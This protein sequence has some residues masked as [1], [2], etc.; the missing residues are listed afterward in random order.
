MVNEPSLTVDSPPKT[1]AKAAVPDVPAYAAGLDSRD[2]LFL[3]A[4]RIFRSELD[5]LSA[6]L[7]PQRELPL[8]QEIH[9]SRIAL[10]RLRVALSVFRDFMPAQV[11][12]FRV[13]FRWL[14]QA[15]GE[16]RDLDVYEETLQG[17]GGDDPADATPLP[18]VVKR[19]VARLRKTASAR[20][21]TLLGS[22]RFAELRQSFAEFAGSD[23]PPGVQRRWRSLRIRDAIEGDL[24]KSLKRVLKAGRKIDVESPPE[25]LHELR[26][27]AK[28]LRYEAEFYTAF[29]EGL[30]VLSRGAKQLQDLLGSQRDAQA[31][32]ER[33]QALLRA[34][35]G[36]AK[37]RAAIAPL[38][39][40]QTERAAK[41]GRR[42][43]AA[44][45]KFEKVAAKTKPGR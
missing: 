9:Q 44:W 18:A 19:S 8:P 23:L 14:A 40:V 29:A 37:A 6:N 5:A 21:V 43:P 42:Y 2:P 22:K 12:H 38:I 28:R 41:L 34:S 45:R 13:E 33:L 25:E 3:L 26:I 39:R 4:Q 16:M 27:R 32:I 20:L 30:S 31:A 10:R 1:E 17:A 11:E 15:L 7:R 35:K 36:D 24:Q